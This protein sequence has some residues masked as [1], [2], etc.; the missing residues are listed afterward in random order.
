VL[1]EAD[2]VLVAALGAGSVAGAAL[3]ELALVEA[4]VEGC[5]SVLVAGAAELLAVVSVLVAGAAELLA[6][7]SVLV[8]GAVELLAV[9]S[10]LVA[11]CDSVEVAAE[12]AAAPVISGCFASPVGA[13]LVDDSVL[14]AGCEAA[15]VS[16]VVLE[17][18]A[19]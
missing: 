3:V 16:E 12:P 5:A 2:S 15:D 17:A 4:D 13:V 8:D 19:D 6:V 14:V 9:V 1:V 10:V 18:D 11:G 7:V